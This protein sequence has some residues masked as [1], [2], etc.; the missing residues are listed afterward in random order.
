VLEHLKRDPHMGDLY[1]FRGR[2]GSLLKIIWH[3]GLAMSL[4]AR[5]LE[6]GRFIWPAAKDGLVSLTSAQLSCLLEGIDWRNPQQ[7]WRPQSAG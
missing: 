2:S 3:D 5:R 7:S 1:V 4:Y 6:K